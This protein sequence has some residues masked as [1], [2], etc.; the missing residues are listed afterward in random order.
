MPDPSHAAQGDPAKRAVDGVGDHTSGL[1][2][3]VAAPEALRADRSLLSA[4]RHK[5]LYTAREL[6]PCPDDEADRRWHIPQNFDLEALGCSTGKKHRNIRQVK[7]K[8]EGL[9]KV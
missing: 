6:S 9:R 3:P 2:L 4:V 8:G 7:S 1:V 5:L